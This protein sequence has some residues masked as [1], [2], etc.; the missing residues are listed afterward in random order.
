MAISGVTARVYYDLVD[1]AAEHASEF[2][3][4]PNR[5]NLPDAWLGV[6]RVRVDGHDYVAISTHVMQSWL[7]RHWLVPDSALR[8]LGKAGLILSP[9]TPCPQGLEWSHPVQRGE[10]T[11]YAV[12]LLWP[13]ADAL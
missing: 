4:G 9:S 10:I 2:V 5:G 11:I 6:W 1:W 12:L 13:D 7:I 3:E 8:A